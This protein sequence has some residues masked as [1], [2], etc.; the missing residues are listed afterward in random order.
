MNTDED[1]IV[2]HSLELVL[3]HDA[4]PR[5]EDRLNRLRAFL[6]SSVPF[7]RGLEHL[8]PMLVRRGVTAACANTAWHGGVGG[9][10]ALVVRVHVQPDTFEGLDVEAGINSIGLQF[11]VCAPLEMRTPEELMAERRRELKER[12][13][14]RQRVNGRGVQMAASANLNL[15]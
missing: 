7:P 3:A 13:P 15:V 10:G 14:G 2:G 8:R 12:Q 11:D 1:A 4:Y 6:S 5:L 9:E